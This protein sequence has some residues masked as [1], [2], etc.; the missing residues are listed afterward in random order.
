VV[1]V[2]A[3]V[4]EYDR[5]DLRLI[6]DAVT[7][8]LEWAAASGFRTVRM[9]V[10]ASGKT[11]HYAARFSL[12]EAVRAYGRW[13][14]QHP[15]GALALRIHLMDPRA[16]LELASGRL[17]VVELLT[18]EDVRFWVEV[19]DGG[20][21][22]EREMVFDNRD[23]PLR[24]IAERFAV[25]RTGWEI[26]VNPRPRRDSEQHTVEKHWDTDLLS[27]GV[28]PGATLR[29]IASAPQPAVAAGAKR[30]KKEGRTRGQ[31]S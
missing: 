28:V 10:L 25:P 30:G 9:Q 7:E 21:V 12:A 15:D 11:A 2:N 27:V 16:L 14:R 19:V 1:A 26:D 6:G 17:D 31:R 18:C 20:Q 24:S 8:L 23:N 13:R 29:F 5:R 22:L 3:R 4:D